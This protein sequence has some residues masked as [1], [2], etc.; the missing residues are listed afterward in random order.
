MCGDKHS[1]TYIATEREAR[2]M[3]LFPTSRGDQTHASPTTG[4][5]CRELQV[6]PVGK[7]WLIRLG[8]DKDF[9]AR[10]PNGVINQLSKYLKG[11]FNNDQPEPEEKGDEAEA[12]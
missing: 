1:N 7:N 10:T 5:Y 9:I 11:L 8:S 6:K 12:L 4:P 3:G 2:G